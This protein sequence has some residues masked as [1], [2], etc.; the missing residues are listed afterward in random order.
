[1]FTSGENATHSPGDKSKD[2]Q[3]ARSA[4]IST[5][6]SA[7][8]NRDIITTLLSDGFRLAVLHAA[9][10]KGPLYPIHVGLESYKDTHFPDYDAIS[11]TW[12]DE[13][14]NSECCHPIYVGGHWDIIFQTRNCCDMLIYLRP[15]RGLKLIWV[16]AICIDQN[17]TD[18]RATQVAEMGQIYAA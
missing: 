8:A 14:G 18:E 17:S 7:H 3:G 10:D 9:G 4:T 2:D 11:Y 15:S 6:D 1:M 12:G 16:D 5:S 13:N